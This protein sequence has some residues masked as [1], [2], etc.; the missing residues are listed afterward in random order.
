[1]KIAIVLNTSWN[2][3]NFRMGLVR[4]LQAQGH[5]VHAIAP[6]DRYS[7]N[8]QGAG[9]IY[10]PLK[11]DARGASFTKDFALI[12]E[13]A[14]LYRKI[15]PAVVLHYTVKPNVYGTLAAALCGIPAINNVCGLGT[16]FL[17]RNLVS[18]VAIAL[19]KISFLF[20]K[21]VFFQNHD[22]L[23]MFVNRRLVS[24]KKTDL[25]PGSGINLD[26]FKAVE[27]RRNSRFTFLMVSR[28]IIDKGVVEFVEAAKILKAKGIQARFQLLG[29]KDTGHKRGIK[30]AII[31]EWIRSGVVEYLGTTNDVQPYIAMADCVVLPSYREGTPRCLLEAAGMSK[32]IVA[33]DV[34]GCRQVVIDGFNG[35]LCEL[36][37]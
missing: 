35:L 25:L 1:M 32:P 9:C 5:E 22:D 34:P 29:A 31:D 37:N 8:L 33:T 19:Y 12:I 23:A 24:E 4:A 28:L 36:K 26:T 2:I 3:Y 21:K 16:I 30:S 18:M 14:A 20:A 6:A 10:H 27:F 7:R 11:M 15:K 13:L 17:T